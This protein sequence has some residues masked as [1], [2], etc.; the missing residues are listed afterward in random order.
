[1]KLLA[2]VLLCACGSSK[3]EPATIKPPPAVPKPQ[4]ICE[5]FS[6]LVAEQCGNFARMNVTAQQCPEV[7]QMALD[8]PNTKD[9][10]VLNAMGDC[11]LNHP[12]CHG[13]SLCIATI[14]FDDPSDLRACTDPSDS[15]A[16]GVDAAAWQARNGANVRTFADAKSTKELPIETC[17][18]QAGLDWL[19]AV[20]CADGSHP[21]TTHDAAEA[22]RAGNVG[23]GGKC[24]SI[25]DLY[26]V[27]CPEAAY[28]IYVDGYVCPRK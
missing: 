6:Q 28:D 23:R 25:I 18:I 15:R 9:G 11:M 17:G 8:T 16:V 22:T 24:G 27:K 7:F 20:P 12:T 3:Q 13:V 19:I 4:A 1:M 10:R 2:L 5:R 21:V 26:Q 14:Q